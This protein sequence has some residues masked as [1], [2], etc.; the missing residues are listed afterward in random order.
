[1]NVRERMLGWVGRV[2]N[3]SYG[4][5]W[6]VANSLGYV[7]GAAGMAVSAESAMRLSAVYRSVAIISG[8]IASL[9]LPVYRRVGEDRVKATDRNEYWL[10]NERPTAAFSAAA[11]WEYELASMLL[12]G[13]GFALI[14]R[15]GLNQAVE[16]IPLDPRNVRPQRVGGEVV[17]DIYV[18]GKASRAVYEDVL[19]FPT[20]GFDGLRSKSVISYAAAQT[21]STSLAAEDHAGRF[22]SN[23]GTSRVALK[24]PASLKPDQID[25]LRANWLKSYG[26]SEN[27]HLPLVLTNGG[28]ATAL[29][30]SAVDQQLLE[31]RRFH[32]EDIARAFGVPPHM[33]GH[34]EK[35]TSWGSGVEQMGIGFVKYTLQ[36][37]LTRIEQELNHKLFGTTRL[38]VEF[39]VEGL[40]RGDSKS[41]GDYYRQ[42]V[43]GSQG[44]GWMTRNE[45]RKL[46]NLPQIDSGDELFTPSGS[47]NV[48][49]QNPPADPAQP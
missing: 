33:I 6:S 31:S 37:H 29:S 26:G 35:T 44:P 48:T 11:F 30:L 16:F 8:A 38:F 49:E 15:D 39:V 24:Y 28:D 46:E 3:V 23:G 12:R 17:Y 34:T 25:Q 36:P 45:I 40:L 22:F 21:I 1:M 14:V 5:W 20:V 43:G 9:P 19:H 10:L 2:L 32:V 42:A 7:P 47:S 18:D 41:R 4:D 27:S 13:D